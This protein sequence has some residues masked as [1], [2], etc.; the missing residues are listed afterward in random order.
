MTNL[1]NTTDTDP[2]DPENA[3]EDASDSQDGQP[4]RSLRNAINSY[5]RDCIYDPLDK[6]AGAWREQVMACTVTHCA[7]YEVRPVSKPKKPK[8]PLPSAV[9]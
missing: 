7:L 2:I 5:C 9:E 4:K 3:L 6:G 1:H 8:K